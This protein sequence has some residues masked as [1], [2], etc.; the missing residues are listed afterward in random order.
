MHAAPS[1]SSRSVST[2]T[3]ASY[4][5]AASVT[6]SVDEP[7]STSFDKF[8]EDLYEIANSVNAKRL[9]LALVSESSQEKCPY[10]DRAT[11]ETIESFL[12]IARSS[13][14]N[15]SGNY[16]IIAIVFSIAKRFRGYITAVRAAL[17]KCFD[18]SL[19]CS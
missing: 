6:S 18:Y 9:A 8:K 15:F 16:D 14:D 12:E 2:S 3:T 1:E 19:L 5:S 11:I 17:G 10:L 13:S 7:M 4:Q